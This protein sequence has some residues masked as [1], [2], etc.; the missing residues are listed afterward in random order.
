MPNLK[1]SIEGENADD[2]ARQ[3]FANTG[4]QGNWEVANGNLPHK[5]V[6]LAVIGTVVGIIGG[7]ATAA[8]QI[9]QWYLNY[10]KS[11]KGLTV[12]IVIDEVR[13][14]L[15]GASAEDIRTILEEIQS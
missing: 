1:L 5:G 11:H 9:R 4:L 7:T 15:E 6:T 2:A 10:K 3:L 13:L 12:V 8:E 14:V